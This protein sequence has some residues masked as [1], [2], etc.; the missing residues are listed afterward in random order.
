MGYGRPA[1]LFIDIEGHE[2]QALLGWPATLE[3]ECELFG[4]TELD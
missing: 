4:S 3:E 2:C 1:M